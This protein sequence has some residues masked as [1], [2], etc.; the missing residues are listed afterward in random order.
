MLFSPAWFLYRFIGLMQELL[1]MLPAV[2]CSAF[3]HI[4]TLLDSGMMHDKFWLCVALEQKKL[5]GYLEMHKV[6]ISGHICPLPKYT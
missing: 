2:V 1:Q 6:T 5:Q 3:A 4:V